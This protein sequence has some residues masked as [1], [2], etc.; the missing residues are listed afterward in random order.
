MTYRA[1]AYLVPPVTGVLGALGSFLLMHDFGLAAGFAVSLVWCGICILAS[2]PVIDW[3]LA[4][5]YR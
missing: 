4:R 1:A 3:L 2:V 5:H